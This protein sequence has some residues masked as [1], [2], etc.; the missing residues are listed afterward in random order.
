[1]ENLT[2]R[3][4]KEATFTTPVVKF[5]EGELEHENGDKHR[6]IRIQGYGKDGN[7]ATLIAKGY[8]DAISYYTGADVI[9]DYSEKSVYLHGVDN[10]SIT[11]VHKL[12]VAKG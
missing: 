3:Q 5:T 12:V 10:L 4:T 2:F 8:A 6:A 7:F 1:M 11:E 9:E